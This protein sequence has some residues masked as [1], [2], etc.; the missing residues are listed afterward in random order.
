[1]ASI[2]IID[3]SAIIREL[4]TDYLLHLGWEVDV[5]IDGMQGIQKALDR[6]YDVIFCDLHLP[7]KNGYQ[8]LTE[9]TR[10]KPSAKFIMTDSMPDELAD[11]AQEA[12]ALYC[13]VKPFDLDQVNKIL[14]EMVQGKSAPCPKQPAK[15]ST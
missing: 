5:A 7:K 6:N 4:L 9:V 13:L 14:Q 3:D 12:G 11:K 8:V 10:L 2:L 15:T 1:M